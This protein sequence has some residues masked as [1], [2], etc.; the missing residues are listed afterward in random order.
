M[1]DSMILAEKCNKTHKS[2]MGLIN[3]HM[4]LL[5]YPVK[6]VKDN[7]KGKSTEF[8]TLNMYQTMALILL[9]QNSSIINKYKMQILNNS[10]DYSE[11]RH[12]A[13][14][15]YITHVCIYRQPDGTYFTGISKN[16]KGSNITY[17]SPGYVNGNSVECSTRY[18][19]KL[20]PIFKADNDKL[21]EIIRYIEY[22]GRQ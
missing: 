13:C 3:T 4:C 6:G 2:V 14:R 10:F 7:E 15:G 19:F 8:Y 5:G 9:M 11:F 20:G 18:K 16:P 22:R 1:I 21:C 12:Y 17:C